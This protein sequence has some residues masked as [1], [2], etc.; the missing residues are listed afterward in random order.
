MEELRLVV[1]VDDEQE[2]QPRLLEF[3]T[4]EVADHGLF[5]SADAVDEGVL[6]GPDPAS[7]A[8]A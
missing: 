7:P 8:L 1:G 5:A 6:G 4:A 2:G 3:E